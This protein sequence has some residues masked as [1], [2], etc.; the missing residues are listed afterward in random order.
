MN[1]P[2]ATLSEPVA[3]QAI[4]DA[5][6]KAI[7]FPDFFSIGHWAYVFIDQVSGVNPAEWVSE[8]LAGNWEAVAKAGDA[9][10]NLSKFHEAFAAEIDHGNA[11]MLQGWEGNAAS[12][13]GKYFDELP[14]S[15]KDQV[16]ALQNVGEQFEQA[17]YGV[18]ATAKTIVSLLELLFD[19]AIGFAIE[20]AATALTSWTGA[21]LVAG[22]GAI[23][24][25]LGRA[26]QVWMDICK[27]HGMA[28]NLCTGA[29]G[30]IAGLLGTLHGFKNHRLPA[31]AYNHPGV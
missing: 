19:L 10:K 8:E 4:P 24:L 18:W 15:L 22:S 27:Y 2:K 7:S 5:I 16:G 20:A 25:T 3:E 9:L 26:V 1:Q 12:A 30:I 13:A 28:W 14:Q 21:G 29:S 17:A 6:D 23:L 31:G 11:D